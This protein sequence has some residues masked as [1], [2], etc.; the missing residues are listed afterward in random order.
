MTYK[1]IIP[2]ITQ[3]EFIKR[4]CNGDKELEQKYNDSGLFAFPCACDWDGC[5]GWAMK[6][7]ENVGTQMDLYWEQK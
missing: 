5:T 1:K 6:T 3:T 7:I 4:Y 2:K